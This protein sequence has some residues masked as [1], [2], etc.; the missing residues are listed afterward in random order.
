VAQPPGAEVFLENRQIK[1]AATNKILS[2]HALTP[3]HTTKYK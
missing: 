2:G 3:P 1:P